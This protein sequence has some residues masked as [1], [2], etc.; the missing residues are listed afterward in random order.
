MRHSAS[1]PP[2]PAAELDT[3]YRELDALFASSSCPRSTRCCKFKQTG[4]TPYVSPPEIERVLKAI[5]RR[6]GRLPKDTT[7]GDCPLLLPTGG[8]SIYADRPFG[9]RTYFCDDATLPEGNRRPE[10][11][12]LAQRLRTLS[13]RSGKSDLVPL[14]THLR[15]GFD[16]TGRRLRG[17]R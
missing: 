7:E 8:C 17:G 3:I 5:D 4:R 11:E 9:C 2:E 16:K 10:V 6:G 15:A 13:E 12:R 14:T 1:M